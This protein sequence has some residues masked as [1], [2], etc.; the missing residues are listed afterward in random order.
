[1]KKLIYSDLGPF[2]ESCK[3]VLFDSQLMGSSRSS[4]ADLAGT[5]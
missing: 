1:M 5:G 4:G 2:Y 3:V